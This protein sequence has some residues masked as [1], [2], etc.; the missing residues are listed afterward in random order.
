MTGSRRNTQPSSALAPSGDRTPPL[1]MAVLNVTPDSFSD[2]GRHLAL[3]SAVSR[4][5]EMA[6]AGAYVIDVGGE[7]TRPGA[8]AGEVTEEQRRVL[9]VIEALREDPILRGVR[10]S[11]DTRNE[12]TARAAVSAG[13]DLINDVSASLWS[14]AS[15]TGAGWVAMH[16]AGE[17]G[18]MQ[19]APRYD[20]VVSEVRHF[21]DERASAAERAGVTEVWVDPGLGF[22]KTTAQNVSLLAHLDL[23]VADGRRL[24]V[25]TSRKRTPGVLLSRSDAALIPHPGPVGG[26]ADFDVGEPTA[27]GDRVEGSLATAV[28]AMIL[29]A[30]MVRAHDISATVAATKAFRQGPFAAQHSF[31]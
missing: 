8:T 15:D 7:S 9:P 26:G 4:G 2:G 1:V 11:I 23:L 16:M 14:V 21:L 25:G 17:P 31:R 30:T 18:T 5:R 3:S 27:P 20:D 24:L 12:T 19:H 22:G 28:W 13:A 29:G 10:I 6:A